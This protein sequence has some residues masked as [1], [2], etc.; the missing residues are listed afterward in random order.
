MGWVGN[1]R[2]GG[3]GSGRVLG[4]AVLFSV[5]TWLP[6]PEFFT[7]IPTY[8]S[9]PSFRD[10][11]RNAGSRLRS[12]RGGSGT[13]VPTATG[14]KPTERIT[15]RHGLG[16]KLTEPGRPLFGVTES[17]LKKG[18]TGDLLE[19]PVDP[20]TGLA[21]PSC[22]SC[23]AHQKKGRLAG[24][25]VLFIVEAWDSTPFLWWTETPLLVSQNRTR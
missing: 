17:G 5:S 13:G 24:A 9:T 22:R 15:N 11:S 14:L 7:H 19:M 25:A 20:V 1:V 12:V 3:N 21:T 18:L 16:Q 4:S 10:R 23:S 8:A 6:P 2:L